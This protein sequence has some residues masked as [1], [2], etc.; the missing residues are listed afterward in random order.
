MLFGEK[1][2]TLNLDIQRDPL[3][4]TNY[5]GATMSLR[6]G[7]IISATAS[8]RDAEL[9]G[10]E[11]ASETQGN[12]TER[13][14]PPGQNDSVDLAAAARGKSA[15]SGYATEITGDTL[16]FCYA[17]ILSPYRAVPVQ[18][19]DTELSAN[20][21]IFKVTHKLTRSIY[22]QS[23]TLRG[24]AV[25]PSKGGGASAPAASASASASFNVQ[26]SIF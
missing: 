6:D 16:P 8:F 13:L 14:L 19:S 12:E 9:L 18:M 4:A 1:R 24:D 3:A 11:S 17:A 21:V 26:L 7:K 25:T 5:N 10:E 20:Y 23:F 22:T 15:K 2:N